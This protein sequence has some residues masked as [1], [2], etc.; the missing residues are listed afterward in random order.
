MLPIQLPL[1]FRD[2]G[3][4]GIRVSL[5]KVLA[6]L[7][8]LVTTLQKR[9]HAVSVD[10]RI[11]LY[12]MRVSFSLQILVRYPRL[13]WLLTVFLSMV[14]RV[15]RSVAIVFRLFTTSKGSPVVSNTKSS[16][17]W[18]VPRSPSL[19]LNQS[20]ADTPTNRVEPTQDACVMVVSAHT[21]G[22]TPT[23]RV[24]SGR[25]GALLCARIQ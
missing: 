10:V 15:F 1:L 11:T 22:N 24:I 20:T 8:D 2:T 17:G 25:Q 19:E 9:L 12:R 4:G 3:Q 7:I 18:T 23:E 6:G 5:N 13:Y 14:V 16:R 21:M